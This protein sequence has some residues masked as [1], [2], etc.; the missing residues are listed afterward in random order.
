MLLCETVHGYSMLILFAL[1]DRRPGSYQVEE[2]WSRCKANFSE[3]WQ[4]GCTAHRIGFHVYNIGLV[5]H[6]MSLKQRN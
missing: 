6:D 4:S 5:A 1:A 2:N 3:H